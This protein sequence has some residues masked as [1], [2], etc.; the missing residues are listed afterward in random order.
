MFPKFTLDNQV[1]AG[2]ITA[3]CIGSDA[4]EEG[5][6]SSVQ[7]LDTQIRQ[8]SGRQ[9]LFANRVPVDTIRKQY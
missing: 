1:N 9:S 4:G 8:H 7:F 2:V 5:G 3:K 6:I